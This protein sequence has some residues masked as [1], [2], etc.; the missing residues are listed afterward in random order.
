MK[1]IPGMGKFEHE[2]RLKIP[3]LTT[4]QDIRKGGDMIELHKMLNGFTKVQKNQLFE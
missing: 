2:G 3:D 4:L 1:Q